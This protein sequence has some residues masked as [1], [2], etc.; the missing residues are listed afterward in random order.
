ML[1][2]VLRSAW[3]STVRGIGAN[4]TFEMRLFMNASS[5]LTR[6]A[7]KPLVLCCAAVCLSLAAQAQTL[8]PQLSASTKIS[9]AQAVPY[10]N[11]DERAVFA[12]LA[13]EIAAQEGAVGQAA[14]ILWPQARQL[15][16]PEL[17]RRTAQWAAQGGKPALAL[18]AALAWELAAPS[19]VAAANTADY[20]LV[21]V[22]RYQALTDRAAA[23]GK[24]VSEAQAAHYLRLAYVTDPKTAANA[25]NTASVAAN[26]YAALLRAWQP[27]END[28]NVHWLLTRIAA[29]A[30]LKNE[31]TL[32]LRA[33][34]R[35]KEPQPEAIFAL[36][37]EEPISAM[38]AA[39][40]WTT[41]S[42]KNVDAWRSLGL[43]QAQQKRPLQAAEAFE[44]GLRLAP[45]D[46]LLHLERMDQLRTAHQPAA[47][48]DNLLAAYA[49]RASI[50]QAR[51]AQLLAEQLEDDYHPAKALELYAI[52][53]SLAKDDEPALESLRLRTLT[54]KARQGDAAS[55]TELL[56]LPQ[57]AN[58]AENAEKQTY[59]AA[60]VLRDLR[61]GARAVAL[62]QA[63][64]ASPAR[65]FELSLALEA[66]GEPT[67]AEALLRGLLKNDP[68]A[69]H[70]LNALG[71]GLID[72]NASPQALAEG[73]AMLEQA[74]A[75][76][77]DSAAIADS[78]GWAYFRA[79]DTAKALPLLQKAY[80]LRRDPEVAAHL[81]ELLFSTGKLREARAIWA[82]G[83]SLDAQHPVLQSTVK[84]FG[85][86]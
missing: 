8:A 43:L 38:Q 1:W 41:R 48:R 46:V 24:I 26:V 54:L 50:T 35:A 39:R 84:R 18:E 82:E 40:D 14:D 21:T 13:S 73:T 7:L 36:L 60:S 20:L 11:W 61:Q 83:L 66:A 44:Q 68:Q 71:Y 33:A 29:K 76:S 51:S 57:S 59:A 75:T 69:S 45:N 85:M 9:N 81:G 52:A 34:A 56:A 80:A 17:L 86:Q 49:V 15:Q 62:V 19:D 27:T 47:A 58:S 28:A 72:R 3:V 74:Y 30:Q 64:P 77:P 70:L 22:Q 78:L 67:Q 79:G 31:R 63:M 37:R 42:P 65:D 23:R 12:F 2:R 25:S 55:L 5:F 53:S 6:A 32:H 10:S 4:F 16:H